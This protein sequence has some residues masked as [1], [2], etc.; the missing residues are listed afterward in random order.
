MYELVRHAVEKAGTAQGF[1]SETLYD[2]IDDYSWNA[3]GLPPEGY[4]FTDTA[5]YARKSMSVYE[6]D[7]ARQDLFARSGFVP[8]WTPS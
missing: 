8:C 1:S 6:W 5:R 4:G 3:D 7:A 2:A